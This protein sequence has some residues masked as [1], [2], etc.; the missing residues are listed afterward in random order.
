MFNKVSPYLSKPYNAYFVGMMSVGYNKKISDRF[1]D[2]S[3]TT[4]FLAAF[5]H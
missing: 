5:S 2:F 3:V 1:N 4:K